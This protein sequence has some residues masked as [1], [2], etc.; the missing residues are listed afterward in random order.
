MTITKKEMLLASEMLKDYSYALGRNVCNDFDFPKSWTADEINSF[1]NRY[2]EWNGDAD[3]IHE[4]SV[5]I[6]DFAVAAFLAHLLK[7][8]QA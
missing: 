7:E 3:E 8:R 5:S 4:P 1:Y 6:P 2:H